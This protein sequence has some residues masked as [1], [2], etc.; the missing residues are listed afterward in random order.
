[1]DSSPPRVMEMTQ[2]PTRIDSTCANVSEGSQAPGEAPAVTPPGAALADPDEAVPL[3]ELLT[4]GGRIEHHP[5]R[6]VLGG[7]REQ[8][9]EHLGA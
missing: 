2:R 3:I 4:L 8:Q 9:P 6:A 7:H 1:M 5:G